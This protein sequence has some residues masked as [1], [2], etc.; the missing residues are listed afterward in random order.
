MKPERATA[1]GDVDQPARRTAGVPKHGRLPDSDNVVGA[2]GSGTLARV[3][4]S[5]EVR[6]EAADLVTDS[7]GNR[8]PGAHEQVR[9]RAGRVLRIPV[10]SQSSAG[11][12]DWQTNDAGTVDDAELERSAPRGRHAVARQ[13]TRGYLVAVS[14]PPA[15]SSVPSTFPKVLLGPAAMKG[16]AS[17]GVPSAR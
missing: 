12:D 8:V 1:F 7:G 2:I 17:Q 9:P 3:A 14:L 6:G 4:G 15:R 13:L 11:A 5:E 16:H 10:V